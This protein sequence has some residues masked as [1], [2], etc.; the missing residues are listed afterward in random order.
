MNNQEQV[1]KKENRIMSGMMWAFAERMGAQLISTIVGIVLARLLLPEAYGIV[2]IVTVFITF[3]NIF[4]T[5]GF[6]NALVQKKQADEKDFNTAFLLS[7]SLSVVLYTI[8]YI[9][10]PIIAEFY[11][12]PELSAVIRVMGLRLPLASINSIQ[13]AF[14]QRAMMFSRFFWATLIGTIISGFVGVIL[15]LNGFGV[16]ALV[17]QY[18]TNTTIDTIM[19]FFICGWIPKLQFSK[20][21]A[22]EIWGFGWKVLATQM[23]YTLEGDVRS[24]IVGKVFGPADLAYYD[25]GKKYPSLLVTNISTTID[26]VMLPAYS[27]HQDEKK[28]LKE[29][30]RKSVRLGIYLLMPV[31]IGFAVVAESF[32]SIILTDKWLFAVPFM[33]IFCLSYLTRPLESSLHQALLAIGKSGVVFICMIA[34]NGIG[35]ALLLIAIFAL[36]SVLWIALFSLLTTLVSYAVFTLA[37]RHYIGYGIREQLQDIMPSAVIAL[38]MGG[39]VYVLSWLPLTDLLV[40]IIQIVVGAL[41]YIVLSH[42]CKLKPFEYIKGLLKEKFFKRKERKRNDY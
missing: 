29:M 22:K 26:K 13:Q 31:L 17:A 36:R 38:M 37:T 20:S 4:V 15:A 6:N 11:A 33:Q 1:S 5:G 12:M 40:L 7:F 21:K 18:L 25:Q 9:L 10:A 39:T 32:V 28:Q 42:I 23:V 24:I 35:L 8:L 34:I 2:A 30:I 27:K 16:W 14:I 3:L 41:E 19:L